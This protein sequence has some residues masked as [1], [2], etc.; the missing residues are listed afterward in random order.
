MLVRFFK[1]DAEKITTASLAVLAGQNSC[2]AV[3]ADVMVTTDPALAGRAI[4]DISTNNARIICGDK[5]TC[6]QLKILASFAGFRELRKAFNPSLAIAP[7][8]EHTSQA[9]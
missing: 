8:S 3:F 9:G 7:P 5:T 4:A 6:C 1:A 2:A